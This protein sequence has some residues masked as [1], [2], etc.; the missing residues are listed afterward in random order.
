LDILINWLLQKGETKA[1]L[2]ISI[3]G[4][5]KTSLFYNS[6]G[7]DGGPCFRVC[8]CIDTSGNLQA[9]L[10]TFLFFLQQ[11]QPKSY[12]FVDLK[13]HAKF[14]NP[15]ITPSGRKVGEAERKENH[16]DTGG[17]FVAHMSGRG[18]SN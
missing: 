3:S 6:A 16:I 7:A 18:R 2:N 5:L 8:T 10:K 14:Q 4:L 15:N 12:F 9:I 1:I 17:I 11:N 13:P